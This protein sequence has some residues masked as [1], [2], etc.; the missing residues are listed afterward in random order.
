MTVCYKCV[1]RFRYIHDF[2]KQLV[3]ENQQCPETI[4]ELQRVEVITATVRETLGVF[5]R[6][7]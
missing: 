1:G 6:Y 5:F 3:Y 4:E 2:M 7:S